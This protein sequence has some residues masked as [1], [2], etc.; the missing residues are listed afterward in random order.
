MSARRGAA[1]WPALSCVRRAADV[2][3]FVTFS[4][5]RERMRM[6]LRLGLYLGV[7]G[8]LT[9]VALVLGPHLTLPSWLVPDPKASTETTVLGWTCSVLNVCMY[10]SP[11]GVVYETACSRK[12]KRCELVAWV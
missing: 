2:A 1:H 9:A 6:L 5:G 3:V 8:L 12:A 10:A 11:L 4:L 7:L